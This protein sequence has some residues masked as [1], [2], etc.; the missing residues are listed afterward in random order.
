MVYK[1]ILFTFLLAS[2]SLYSQNVNFQDPEFKILLINI[3][4]NSEIAKDLAGNFTK[5]DVNGDGEI[6]I[7][8]AENISYIFIVNNQKIKDF[9][10]I[11]YFKN[12]TYLNL[13][14]LENLEN[15]DITK[16]IFLKTLSLRSCYN[17]K[18]IDVSKNTSLES[19]TVNNANKI[20]TIDVTKNTNLEQFYL[21]DN[22][23]NLETLFTKNGKNQNF[24]QETCNWPKLN[25]VCC[26]ES[27]KAFFINKN[28]P[29]VVTDCLLSSSDINQNSNV[30]FYPNPTTEEIKFSQKVDY[31]KVFGTNGN[32]IF[33]KKLDNSILSVKEISVGVYFI[34]FKVKNKIYYQKLIKK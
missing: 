19:F 21:F 25:Y 16:N 26:D 18:S 28:I 9:D 34:E 24:G 15:L 31:V 1:T 4:P 8:E 14:W 2:I 11:E 13:F 32:L 23:L 29:T 10:G 5:V 6:Q 33:D 7:S 30:S 3:T 27:E 22:M 17:I 12:I 20:K